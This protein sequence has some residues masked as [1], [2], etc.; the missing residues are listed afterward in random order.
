MLAKRAESDITCYC[1][2][3]EG[4]RAGLSRRELSPRIIARFRSKYTPVDGCWLWAAGKFANGY[5]QFCIGR[6]LDGRQQNT[7][8]HR[9]AFVVHH[10]VDIPAGAVVMHSCD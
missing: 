4:H 7:Q 3:R 1:T 2:V 8:A 5:G 9:V 10:G 6:D